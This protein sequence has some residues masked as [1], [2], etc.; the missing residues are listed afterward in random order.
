METNIA[1]FVLKFIFGEKDTVKSRRDM[2][3]VGVRRELW[4]K[5]GRIRQTYTK[6]HTPY[7]LTEAERKIF[8]E[9]IAQI[10]VFRFEIA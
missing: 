9:A 2:Q 8:G 10:P 5:P 1:K 7:V 4:L 3:A 6:L